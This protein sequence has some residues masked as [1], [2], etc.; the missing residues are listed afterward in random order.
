MRTMGF[1]SRLGGL[2]GGGV[3]LAVQ[4][5]AE[6]LADF[7]RGQPVGQRARRGGLKLEPCNPEDQAV[8]EKMRVMALEA[9][10][11]V[12]GTPGWTGT[13]ADL[14]V[15]QRL[16]DDGAFDVGNRTGLQCLGVVLGDVMVTT[17]GL[18]WVVWVDGEE[19]TPLLER[20]GGGAGQVTVQPVGMVATAVQR[21]GVVNVSAMLEEAK[22]QLG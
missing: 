18:R 22:R 15:L 9:A 3:K 21:G 20:A 16:V 8:L 4:D 10:R 19:R 17:L 2:L 5:G 12:Y 11:M 6:A 7:A 13:P 14:D 1:F